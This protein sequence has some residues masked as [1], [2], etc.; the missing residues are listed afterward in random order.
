M[1]DLKKL[2]AGCRF[3]LERAVPAPPLLRMIAPVSYM[4]SYMLACMPWFCTFYAG[5]IIKPT[6]QGTR[7]QPQTGAGL[8]GPDVPRFTSVPNQARPIHGNRARFWP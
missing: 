2:F 5:L 3:D 6:S 1:E 7:E 8:R 4:A